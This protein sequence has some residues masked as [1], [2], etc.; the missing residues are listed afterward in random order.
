MHHDADEVSQ[1]PHRN[2]P[3]VFTKHE[4]TIRSK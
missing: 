3:P 2:L 4:K 1:L